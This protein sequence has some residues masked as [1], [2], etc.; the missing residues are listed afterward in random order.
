MVVR[1]KHE[2]AE[3]RKEEDERE[4]VQLKN[5]LCPCTSLEITRMSMVLYLC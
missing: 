3:R 1:E 2:N 4:K 5:Q